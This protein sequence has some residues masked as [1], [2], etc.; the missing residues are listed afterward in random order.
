MASTPLKSRVALSLALAVLYVVLA[1]A[2]RGRIAPGASWLDPDQ[3]GQIGQTLCLHGQFGIAPDKPTVLRGPAYPGALALACRT[4][5]ADVAHVAPIVNGILHFALLLTLAFHPLAAGRAG[6]IGLIAVGLDPLLL[7]YGART[8]L[9]PMMILA[10]A[11]VI[12]TFDAFRRRPSPSSA[13][14]LGVS[15]GVSMLVKPVLVYLPPVLFIVA[16]W[17]RRAAALYLALSLAMGV[18]LIAPWT[19]RNF[20]VFGQAIPVASGGWGIVLKGDTFSRYMFEAEGILDL[21]ARAKARLR[22]IDE[23]L[24]IAGLPGYEKDSYYR[25]VAMDDWRQEPTSLVRKLAVQSLAFWTLGG[26]RAK[27]LLF[28]ALQLP[29][30]FVFLFALAQWLP[31]KTEALLGVVT[32]TAYLAA[33]HALSLAIA[34][35]S[36]PVRPWLVLVAV[37]FLYSRLRGEDSMRADVG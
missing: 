26:S 27:T 31:T 6:M 14:A 15:W 3:I 4:L 34:R 10:T 35:Y 2:L 24:G 11:L 32:V 17:R 37:S 33:V 22:Q 21:E 25:T 19:Y 23:R 20:T 12:A 30:L 36:L 28:T 18:A 9:E 7:N 5:G 29:V 1:F 8:Y 13:V 16:L